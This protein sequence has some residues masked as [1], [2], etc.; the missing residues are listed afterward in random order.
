V[1]SHSGSLPQCAF[2]K[3][4]NV[5]LNRRGCSGYQLELEIGWNGGETVNPNRTWAQYGSPDVRDHDGHRLTAAASKQRANCLDN[6]QLL[7]QFSN[8]LFSLFRDVLTSGECLNQPE[9][10]VGENPLA[11]A[12][13]RM[14]SMRACLG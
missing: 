10:V 9:I 2:E 8:P 13:S 6:T 1:S 11:L 7:G 5:L 12:S 3:R 14:V 4:S